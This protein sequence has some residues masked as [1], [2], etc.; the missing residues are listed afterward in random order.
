M[1]AGSQNLPPVSARM[2]QT[3]GRA[4]QARFSR[5]GA[6]R[7][8]PPIEQRFTR[9]IR[10]ADDSDRGN[11]FGG[12]PGIASRKRDIAKATRAL[13]LHPVNIILTVCLA[14]G[15][16]LAYASHSSSGSGRV[17]VTLQHLFLSM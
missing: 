10:P 5:G 11:P 12:L 16:G 7:A 17:V 4:G 2:G 14:I 15:A 8:V 1:N 9:P 3:P 6:P 13:T